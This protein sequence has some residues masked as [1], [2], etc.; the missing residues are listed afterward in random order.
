[1]TIR[2]YVG[3]VDELNKYLEQFPPFQN[4]Q[5]LPTVELLEALEFSVPPRWQKKMMEMDF[6]PT[7]HSV[8]EFIQFCERWERLEMTEKVLQ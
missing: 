3:R 5:T 6:K 2:E 8:D 4:N 1:M 7:E